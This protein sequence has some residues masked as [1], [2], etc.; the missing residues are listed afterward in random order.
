MTWKMPGAEW[1]VA[2]LRCQPIR[3]DPTSEFI[4]GGI[5]TASIEPNRLDRLGRAIDERLRVLG[6]VASD[7][8]FAVGC[9]LSPAS[10]QPD[11]AWREGHLSPRSVRT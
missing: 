5:G 6:D 9:A 4:E 2:R 3:P 11:R 8:A 10:V 7:A 1:P